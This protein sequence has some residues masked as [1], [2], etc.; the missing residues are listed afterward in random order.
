MNKIKKKIK[1]TKKNKNKKIAN[2]HNNNLVFFQK[3]FKKISNYC[4]INIRGNNE[5]Y[6]IYSEND[7][8]CNIDIKG[9]FGVKIN[10]IENENTRFF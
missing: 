8:K 5:A 7:F 6:H 10:R 4:I 2:N 3:D 9:I 1:I